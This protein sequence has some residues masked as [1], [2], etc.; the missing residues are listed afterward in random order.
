MAQDSFWTT[1]KGSIDISC[2]SDEDMANSFVLVKIATDGDIGISDNAT[3]NGIGVLQEKDTDGSEA[4]EII[5]VR[6]QGVS[7]V[8]TS[9][10]MNAGVPVTAATNGWAVAAADGEVVYGKTL[11]NVTGV[12]SVVPCII[13][14]GCYQVEDVV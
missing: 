14:P 13:N 3:D 4:G 11:V 1:D 5:R 9:A 7:Y 8:R 6:I 10:T 2:V 12:D